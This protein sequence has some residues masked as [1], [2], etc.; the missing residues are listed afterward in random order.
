MP[1]RIDQ[2]GIVE[3]VEQYIA[4]ERAN[5][6]TPGDFARAIVSGIVKGITTEVTTRTVVVAVDPPDVPVPPTAVRFANQTVVTV[7]HPG[8][9]FIVDDNGSQVVGEAV[10]SGL[11]VTVTF[12]V[13]VTG[14]I[15]L[16]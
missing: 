5:S 10:R 3:R 7:N 15:Y 13:P 9:V 16:L 4:E 14:T 8:A 12:V 11:T 2:T 6:L 1:V